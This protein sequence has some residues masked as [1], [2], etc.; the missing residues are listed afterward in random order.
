MFFN[1]IFTFDGSGIHSFRIFGIAIFDL[2]GTIL[3]AILTT[4]F[5]SIRFEFAL[6]LWFVI[7]ELV[8]KI[9]GIKTALLTMLQI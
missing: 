3:L 4:K 7:G 9:F 1:K 6:I 8:H 5:L 2:L